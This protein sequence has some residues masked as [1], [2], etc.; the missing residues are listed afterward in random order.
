MSPGAELFE[1]VVY[2]GGGLEIAGS[3]ALMLGKRMCMVIFMSPK[4][5][6]ESVEL[7]LGHDR[8]L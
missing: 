6:S 7:Y 4:D 1:L 8:V 2:V 5:S 3:I